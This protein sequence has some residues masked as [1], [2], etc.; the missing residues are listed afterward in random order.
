MR[1]G[2]EMATI[3]PILN[4]RGFS[5]V[6]VM[7][8]MVILAFSILG[9]TSM[10]QYANEVLLDGM[11]GA[12]ALAMAEGR[13]EVK[14]S[15]PWDA[16]LMDDFDAD[17]IAEI[18][19]RDDG[20]HGDV[21]SGDG[22]YSG[23]LNKM[24]FVSSGPFSLSEAVRWTAQRWFSSKLWRRI[25]LG[26]NRD[27]LKP[28]R[29]ASILLLWVFIEQHMRNPFANNTGICLAEVMVAMAAGGVILSAT[30]QALTLFESK[31]TAQQSI[32]GRH[33]DQR[34]GLHVLEEELRL[35]G[36]GSPKGTPAM[37]TLAAQ[38]LEFTANL[39]NLTTV[40]TEPVSALQ[41]DLAVLNGSNWNEGKHIV[42]CS[43]DHCAEGVLTRDGRRASL[44]LTASLGVAF[45]AG[46][47]VFVSN[48]VRYYI[49]ATSGGKRNV[50]R[51][52]DGGANAIIG[53]VTQF[54]LDYFNRQGQPTRDAASVSRV[55]IELAVGHDRQGVISEV[56]L[57]GR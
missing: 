36:T 19:M 41:Q 51:Q 6:E 33:Q 34:L 23:L 17:G 56:A 8:S 50:M 5:L 25:R 44:N 13:V 43:T 26:G 2:T 57:R 28:G 1:K 46:S 37:V 31:L 3:R 4:E 7:V 35:A 9:V 38:E 45:P 39:D 12:Q 32:I 11:K 29:F 15:A 24:A 48:R 18:Q 22:I 20:M 16:L 42:I 47:E 53:D 52:V 49:S 14:R 40:L 54:Q 21:L 10:F 30:F 27:R 55:R